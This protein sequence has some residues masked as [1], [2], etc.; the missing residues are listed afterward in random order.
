VN[1]RERK[2]LFERIDEGQSRMLPQFSGSWMHVTTVASWRIYVVHDPCHDDGDVSS[3]RHTVMALHDGHGLWRILG[4][5]LPYQQ[6]LDI[7]E[8]RA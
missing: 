7:A 2:R 5:E 3:D 1:E 6:A 4:R 8:G